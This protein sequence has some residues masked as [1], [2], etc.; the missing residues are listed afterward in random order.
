MTIFC[1]G[2]G[3]GFWRRHDL[4]ASLEEEL[5]TTA[6]VVALLLVNGAKHLDCDG[7]LVRSARE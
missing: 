5:H 1:G 3:D 2:C 7:E 6:L 4:F